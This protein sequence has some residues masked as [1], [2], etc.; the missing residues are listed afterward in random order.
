MTGVQDK[1]GI[2]LPYYK[3][4][5]ELFRNH[6]PC[7]YACSIWRMLADY[8]K[9]YPTVFQTYNKIMNNYTDLYGEK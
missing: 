2:K 4:Y 8:A 6:A 7:A 3:E 5:V 1:L 9:D